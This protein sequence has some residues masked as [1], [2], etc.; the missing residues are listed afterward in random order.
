MNEKFSDVGI[1]RED[2]SIETKNRNY[3]LALEK[4]CEVLGI[5]KVI[6]SNNAI[7][8]YGKDTGCDTRYIPAALCPSTV[9]EVQEIVKIAQEHAIPIYPV[10]S[11]RNWGYGG[12]NPVLNDSVVIDLSGLDKIRMLD[13]ETN[14]VSVEAGVTQGQLRNWL[15]ERGIDL[16]IPATGS[17]PGCS[18]LGNVMERGF[19]MTPYTDHFKATTTIEAVLP[20]GTLYRPAMDEMGGKDA[21]QVFKWGIGPYLDGMFTQGSFGIVTAMTFALAPMPES[22]DV[23][24]FKIKGKGIETTIDS[25]RTLFR[26][27][28]GMV[29]AVNLMNQYRLV[30]TIGDFPKHLVPDD[31]P[32][33]RDVV[34]DLAKQHRLPEWMGMGAIYC[35]KSFVRKA[36]REIRKRLAPVGSAPL[37]LNPGRLR[38][39]SGVAKVVP[40][41]SGKSL[42]EYLETIGRSLEILK[43]RPSEVAMPMCYWRSGK[44]PV[45]GRGFHPANDGCGLMWFM[46]LVPLKKEMV[47]RYSDMV[48]AVCLEYGLEPFLTLTVIS[49][50]CIESTVPL[51]FDREDEAALERARNCY[52]ELFRRGKEIGVMPNRL[53]IDQMHYFEEG[54]P[55]V[56]KL[57][58]R[59]HKTLD[60]NRIMSS[61]RYGA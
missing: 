12:A 17:G 11:G 29:V 33:P 13:V 44:K 10:S 15:D 36:R 53:S 48:E 51:L 1:G 21:D 49:E 30:S 6:N 54:A 7:E 2:D 35:P 16:M 5:E 40:G 14:L 18:L 28:P 60:P 9:D 3:F 26:D 45:N 46:A 31:G 39:L 55:E 24:F 52:D 59:I 42:R 37:F 50:Q 20:D 57:I 25:V 41:K 8:H 34:A 19:G 23:F 22:V 4:W 58:R 38:I 43:G 47:K 27:L 32:L 61:G 56:T